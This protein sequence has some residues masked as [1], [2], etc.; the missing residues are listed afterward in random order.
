MKRHVLWIVIAGTWIS[1]LPAAGRAGEPANRPAIDI[2]GRGT[3]RVVE[4]QPPLDPAIPAEVGRL[5]E[6]S[7]EALRDRNDARYQAFLADSLEKLPEFPPARWHSGYVRLDGAW[8]HV[9]QVPYLAGDSDTLREYAE[10]R[11]AADAKHFSKATTAESKR[12]GLVGTEAVSRIPVPPRSPTGRAGAI[13]EERDTYARERLRLINTSGYS[14]GYVR[15]QESLARW[16]ADNGLTEESRVHWE[17]VFSHD[18]TNRAAAE[19]LGMVQV[20]GRFVRREH[21]EHAREQEAAIAR[22]LEKWQDK[23]LRLRR[24]ATATD[25]SRRQTSLAALS[26]IDDPEAIFAVERVFLRRDPPARRQELVE[27]AELTGV[28]VIAKFDTQPATESLVRFATLHGRE[29]VRQAASR[30][31]SPRELHAFVPALLAGLTLPIKYEVELVVDDLG[32]TQVQ[33]EVTQEHE[34]HIVGLRDTRSI[35]GGKHLRLLSAAATA[36]MNEVQKFNQQVTH[37]N[38][39]IASALLASVKI[40]TTGEFKDLARA[41]QFDAP[42]P[43]RWWEWWYDYNEQYVSSDKP[44]YGYDY[45][46]QTYDDVRVRYEAP[47]SCFAKGTPVWTLS[48]ATPIEQVKV[49]DR[50]L[51][52]DAETGELSYKGVLRTTIRPPSKMLTIHAGNSRITTTLGHPFFVVGK[53]WRMAKQLREDDWV[54]AQGQTLPIDAIETTE[55]AEAHNLVVADF[56]TYF[57]GKDRVLVHDN[58]PIRPVRLEMPGLLASK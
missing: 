24:A 17:Q 18:T 55:P 4:Q 50:L 35:R 27:A 46:W 45:G 51:S 3:A 13:V 14:A 53:G 19:A 41:T 25:A 8:V 15:A 31:R 2:A 42:D 58:S 36:R 9:D 47:M 7:L 5:V 54:Y 52:Q 48:G 11:D 21:V 30:A 57:V 34:R 44:Y 38:Q 12:V 32:E 22:S 10:R 56:G 29:T 37:V 16:C 49:G 23:I 6:A 26:A 40:D 20:G 39:R 43:K 33:A 1:A 28:A